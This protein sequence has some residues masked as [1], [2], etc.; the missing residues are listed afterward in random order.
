MGKTV[1]Q[2]AGVALVTPMYPDL[3]IN[4][5]M[6]DQMIDRQLTGH[7]DAIVVVGTSGEGSTLTDEEHC[8]VV[9]H[10]V[11]RVNHRIPVIAGVGS[12]NTSHAVELSKGAARAGA[13]ALLHVTPYYNQAS[14]RGLVQHVNACANATDL[15]VILYNIPSRTGV[16]IQ[17]ETYLALC[18]NDRIVGVK[19]ASGNFSQM[20]TIAA[21]CGDRL[22]IYSGNDDQTLPALALGAKGIISVLSNLAPSVMHSICQS[23]FDGDVARSRELQLQYT[24]LMQALFM[25]V[26]PIPVKQ[27]L[28]MMGMDV[29]PCRPPLCAMEKHDIE[30]LWSVLQQYCLSGN[31]HL[32]EGQSARCVGM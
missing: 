18:E 8:E 5:S 29:G 10:T 23:F 32:F 25:D 9:E 6:L 2:G 4:Y 1:F 16:N 3:R 30:K 19:E 31:V 21:L 27:A 20:A 26:N 28:C 14:Q 24:N 17:P 13:D 11:R 12:N 7:T 22:D 15:P